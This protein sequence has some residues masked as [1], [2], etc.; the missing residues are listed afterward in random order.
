LSAADATSLPIVRVSFPVT[1]FWVLEPR[2]YRLY[3]IWHTRVRVLEANFYG[4]VLRGQD[5]GKDQPW[6][7]IL[8]DDYT[9]G[10]ST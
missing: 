7:H 8:A 10:Y 9:G 2:R 5:A 6:N 1:V 3:D 4:P